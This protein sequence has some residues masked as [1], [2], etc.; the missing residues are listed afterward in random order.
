MKTKNALRAK[1]FG[2]LLVLLFLTSCYS[3]R[4]KTVEGV[5]KPDP[6]SERNDYFRDMMVVEKDTVINMGVVD[7]DFT[8][9]IDDCAD[10]GLHTVE[11]RNTF[12]G[13]LLNAVTFGRKRQ[14]RLKYVCMKPSN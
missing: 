14:V 4:F 2:I 13:I 11:Y 9:L 12:G 5:P 3:V 8:M 6:F 7:K 1:P 10:D